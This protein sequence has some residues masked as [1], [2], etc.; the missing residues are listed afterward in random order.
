MYSTQK[1]VA[2]FDSTK[3]V[4]ITPYG[5]VLPPMTIKDWNKYF[6]CRILEQAPVLENNGYIIKVEDGYGQSDIKLRECMQGKYCPHCGRPVCKSDIDGYV[7]QCFYCDED[8]CNFELICRQSEVMSAK[9][10]MATPRPAIPVLVL[11]GY[12]ELHIVPA[13]DANKDRISTFDG[14]GGL[15][16]KRNNRFDSL[17]SALD[18]IMNDCQYED[19]IVID[20]ALRR[21]AK[22]NNVCCFVEDDGVFADLSA[23]YK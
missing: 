21:Q 7:A 3:E 9:R 15:F 16:E 22:N 19:G 11:P 20:H 8:F 17:E 18:Y 6:N 4:Y 1:Y 14:C 23:E 12:Y 13:T 2:I 5:G 10:G